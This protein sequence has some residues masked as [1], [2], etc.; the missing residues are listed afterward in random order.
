M[1]PFCLRVI[2]TTKKKANYN[3]RGAGQLSDVEA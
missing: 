3:G 1:L 2:L